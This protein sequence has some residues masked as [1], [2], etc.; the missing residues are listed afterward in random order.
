MTSYFTV[1]VKEH[2]TIE[3]GGPS[4]FQ[5]LI[6]SD[7]MT[8]L[9][10]NEE[11][12]LIKRNDSYAISG[13]WISVQ[14]FRK[15]FQQFMIK[16]LKERA[17]E[18]LSILFGSTSETTE[19]P[20][21]PKPEDPKL[22]AV[23]DVSSDGSIS[24]KGS[25]LNPDVLALMQKTGANKH[26]ALSY[27]LQTA[28][29][30]INCDDP[31]EKEKI[32]EELFSAYRE[33]MMGG[34]LKEHTLPVEDVQQASA[35]VDECNKTFNHTYFRYDP[36]KK[37]IKC[38][39]TDARQMQNVRR[40]LNVMKKDPKIKSVFIDFP[41]RSRRVTIKLG[42]II[43]EEVDV[44]V[45]AANDRLMHA[46]GVAAAIDRASYG[47]VQR[48][49]N[50][51]IE[52]TGALPTG[53]AVITRAGGKLKC[54]FVVH[55]VGPIASQHKDQCG[56]LLHNACVNSM[57]MAQR[58]KAKSISFPPISS[59][60]FGVPKE[61]VAN[62]MLCSLCSYTC[63]DPELLNDVRI[64][65]IDEPTFDVFLKF[66]HKERA[67]L[68]LLQHAIPTTISKSTTYHHSMQ[69]GNSPQLVA[70]NS[71]TNLV[72]I[73]LPKLA[74]RV[75]IKLGDI[76]QERVDVIV[77]AA[78]MHL[79]LN[80][81][82]GAAIDKASGGVVQR[83]CKKIISSTTFVHTGDA[84]ATSAG[85]TLKCNL[86]IHTV[87][88]IA[89][90]HKNQC[91]SLLK[92][93]CISALNVATNFEAISVAFPPISSGNCGVSTELVASVM[94]STLCSYKCSNPALLNDVRIVI[95]DKPTFEVFLN[96]FHKE[97][98]SLD[99]V[100][101]NSTTTS[102]I[103]K[104]PTFQFGQSAVNLFLSEGA[105]ILPG[106]AQ[107]VLYS[108]AVTQQSQEAKNLTS[109][110]FEPQ[111]ANP[112]QPDGQD[113][114]QAMPG[115][116][117]DAIEKHRKS[118][119]VVNEPKH[120]PNNAHSDIITHQVTSSST[121]ADDENAKSMDNDNTE[122]GKHGEDVPIDSYKTSSNEENSSSND[123]V[124]V[125]KP[126][127]YDSSVD[128]DLTNANLK[129]PPDNTNLRLQ[130]ASG[131]H[132]KSLEESS[133]EQHTPTQEASQNSAIVKQ[134]KTSITLHTKYLP[135]TTYGG[136]TSSQNSEIKDKSK[137]KK[138]DENAESNF[139]VIHTY[140]L[141]N[142][143]SYIIIGIWLLKNYSLSIIMVYY[144]LS[145]GLQKSTMYIVIY[146]CT[147]I[148]YKKT[149]V[150]ATN[151]ECNGE[152]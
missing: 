106:H 20:V 44:I 145:T 33:L 29:I 105:T 48:E 110:G 78:N 8:Q 10:V 4:F 126:T 142:I 21:H 117:S 63:S 69:V 94:L 129:P 104:P 49:S 100:Y 115:T 121:N 14:N 143:R 90:T 55:A 99:Q 56:P 116:S 150:F 120:D 128:P 108:Q 87:G 25:S 19:S 139:Y 46:G 42:D 52:Q 85:G 131:D 11:L 70:Q 98:Q 28:T 57:I 147:K 130:P 137:E 2:V 103:L 9:I 72:S 127:G 60:L 82:V 151:A 6:S 80:V 134:K 76:V 17:R 93:A 26:P 148:L 7:E 18:D 132:T 51:V 102:G 59:G 23:E 141:L 35:M 66:F 27:D 15:G 84:V 64:V 124:L 50:K 97:Q 41:K 89:S 38:L 5:T 83:E 152:S 114:S 3:M 47:A 73:D 101:N 138:N 146:S 86:V 122:D 125:E 123:F 40:R 113:Y 65:I 149:T 81:G 144:L 107:P 68:E 135:S 32:K 12:L 75:T 118:S 88:P 13:N 62:V 119:L 91:G 109:G 95:I 61:L 22:E 54:E 37:E 1:Q 133:D 77:N 92:K 74:R 36:E 140:S 136:Q 111:P 24:A 112:S 53:E 30:N 39:S 71:L 34:K 79:L 45:N 43:E 67:N 16:K 31:T 58:N 96:V